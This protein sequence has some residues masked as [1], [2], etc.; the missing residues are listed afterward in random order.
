M[1]ADTWLQRAAAVETTFRMA[2][3][4]GRGV[5]V[6]FPAAEEAALPLPLTAAI[7]DPYQWIPA[8][9]DLCPLTFPLKKAS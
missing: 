2:A 4:G 9:L 3:A 1:L 7:Q 6:G 5:S 8:D